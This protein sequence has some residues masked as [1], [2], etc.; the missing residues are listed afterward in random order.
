M[1]FSATSSFV[2]A[3]VTGAAGFIALTRY[4][5]REDAALAA[6]P[7]IFAAQQ[8]IEGMLWLNLPDP[9]QSGAAPFL[10]IAF[11]LFAKALWPAYAPAAAFLC[12]PDPHRRTFI[13]ALAVVGLGVGLYFTWSV[14]AYGQVAS[15]VGG[16]HIAYSGGPPVPLTISIGYF[17]AT[18]VAPALSSHWPVRLFA[19]TVAASSIVTYYLFWEAFSSV[20]CYFAAAASAVIVLH[21]E[22]ERQMREA[23]VTG[24]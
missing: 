12:E 8:A 5:K 20:W 11:L 3:V 24:R 9:P 18:V 23:A 4:Q 16:H 10:T 14:L 6:T 13:G 7:L 1:C 19:G 22:R 21:F 17:L 15:I 2:A